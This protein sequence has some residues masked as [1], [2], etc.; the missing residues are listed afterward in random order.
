MSGMAKDVTGV[1][2]DLVETKLAR[3]KLEEHEGTIQGD[4]ERRKNV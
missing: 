4:A 3:L 2:R 1:R